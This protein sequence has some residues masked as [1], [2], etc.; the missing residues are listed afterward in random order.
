MAAKYVNRDVTDLEHAKVLTHEIGGTVLAQR[1]HKRGGLEVEVA[2]SQTQHEI[3][4]TAADE[5]RTATRVPDDV[6]YSLV[7]DLYIGVDLDHG[8]IVLNGRP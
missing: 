3:P 8:P 5:E 7:D 1:V 2:W 4:D 6:E